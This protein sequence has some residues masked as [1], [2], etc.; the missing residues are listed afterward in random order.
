[1]V[2][3]PQIQPVPFSAQEGGCGLCSIMGV[4]HRYEMVDVIFKLC[5]GV[6]CY[7]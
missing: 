1:M 3:V 5:V 7:R 4:A 6:V 2:L